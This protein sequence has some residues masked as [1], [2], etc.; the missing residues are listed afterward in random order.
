MFLGNQVTNQ[1]YESAS[2]QDLGNSP[3]TMEAARFADCI[4][5]APE[6]TVQIADAIQAYVQADLGGDSCWVTLPPE[7]A[8]K[9]GPWATMRNPVVRLV[10]ALYGHP[11]SGTF[12]EK[13][14]DTCVRSVGFRDRPKRAF[15]RDIL[16]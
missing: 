2:F 16:A 8:P 6:H 12:W 1:F 15:I 10:K 11:D 13:R 5:C 3:A 9:D 7:I 4:G 14:C